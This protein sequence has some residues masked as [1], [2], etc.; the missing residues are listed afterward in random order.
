MLAE[1]GH[2]MSCVLGISLVPIPELSEPDELERSRFEVSDYCLLIRQVMTCLPGLHQAYADILDASDDEIETRVIKIHEGR[3]RSTDGWAR[4]AVVTLSA[5]TVV[6]AAP[7]DHGMRM[8][9]LSTEF[10]RQRTTI[11]VPTFR[12]VFLH[13]HPI[14]GEVTYIVME[15][16][17]GRTL[18]ACWNDL[19]F[20]AKIRVAWTLRGY[21]S[22][23]HRIRR[24]TPGPV[25]HEMGCVGYFFGEHPEGPFDSYAAMNDWFNHKLKV[26]IRLDK[27][28]P[29][30]PPFTER[31]PLVLTHGDLNMGNIMIS[32]DGIIYLI[33]WESTGFYPQS[34]EYVTMHHLPDLPHLW[35]RL[36]PFI[37]RESAAILITYSHTLM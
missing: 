29:D 2:W 26:S 30:T 24:T 23:L 3:P 36:I 9:H 15:R 14:D 5:D 8:D 13:S 28:P 18:S 34:F 12:R 35:Y 10:V 21:V 1:L 31:W 37:T 19:G 20:I 32:N 6:K 25:A 27:A 22:Q 16:I 17:R 11:P 33:D 7:S 4:D